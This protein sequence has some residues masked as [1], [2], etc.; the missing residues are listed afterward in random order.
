[1]SGPEQDASVLGKRIRAG[2]ED[3]QVAEMVDAV[4]DDSDDDD[5]GP[6]PMPADDGAAKKKRKGV[7]NINLCYC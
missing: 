1:M 4:E 3:T 6:M 2:E 7:S 5:V